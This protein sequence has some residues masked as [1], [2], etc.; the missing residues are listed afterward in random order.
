MNQVNSQRDLV[1]LVADQDMKATLEALLTRHQA[2]GI[3]PIQYVVYKHPGHDAGC[4][5]QGV[6][7]LRTFCR[8]FTHALLIFDLEGS[9][10][11]NDSPD[12]VESELE[13]SLCRNGWTDDR[14]AVI[15]IVP[16]LE[17][18]IWSDSPHV[19]QI[20]GW[21]NRIP[22]FREWLVEEGFLKSKE[23]KPD[24]PKE[25]FHHALR[26]VR[27]QPSSALFKQMAE[28]VSFRNCTD[29]RFQ[30]LLER[31]Q[32]WFAPTNESQN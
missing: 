7:F 6:E 22:P 17:I 2:L 28:K 26:K 15:V 23:E 21:E 30:K 29:S 8:Q 27:K 32:K 4:R 24:R 5:T 13:E 25:A 9:G 11:D 14:A 12:D 18:W 20:C 19:D 31:L 3:R 16:E 10:R 1:I